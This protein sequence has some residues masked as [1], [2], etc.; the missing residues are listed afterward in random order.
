MRVYMYGSERVHVLLHIGLWRALR[1]IGI[2]FVRVRV[3]ARVHTH[4]Y[5]CVVRNRYTAC[6]RA[7][8]CTWY[9]IHVV[10]TKHVQAHLCVCI[11]IEC[12]CILYKKRG[13]TYTRQIYCVRV[14]MCMCMCVYV[15]ARICM[16]VCE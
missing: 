15:N 2:R 3:I 5:A 10:T 14:C 8:E 12:V 7:G 11:H 6:M 1:E 4:K 13:G 16:C 9:T